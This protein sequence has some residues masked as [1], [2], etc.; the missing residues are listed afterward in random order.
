MADDNNHK[1]RK[2]THWATATAK[3]K[4]V[5]IYFVC[6]KNRSSTDTIAKQSILVREWMISN[7]WRQTGKSFNK[8]IFISFGSNNIRSD[9][10]NFR[11][12]EQQRLWG[13][14]NEIMQTQ[15]NDCEYRGDIFDTAAG[16]M[17]LNWGYSLCVYH[18]S[19]G[20]HYV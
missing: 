2:S 10:T 13:R 5:P 19:M 20:E 14:C 11:F 3:R 7:E 6:A 12:R 9:Q 17:D 8:N 18:A 15:R 16:S 1:M 4:G